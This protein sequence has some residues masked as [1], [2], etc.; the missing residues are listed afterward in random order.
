MRVRVSPGQKA[1]SGLKPKRFQLTCGFVSVS[2][3]QKAGSGLKQLLAT[4][5]IQR[6]DVSP[7]QK[8]GSGLKQWNP[9]RRKASLSGVSPGQKAGSGLKQRVDV[10]RIGDPASFSRPKSREWIETVR[11]HAEE[12]T[13]V[14]S[15]GQ[16]AGSGLKPITT[17]S[18]VVDEWFLPAKKP[19]VD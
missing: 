5:L 3:G 11:E 13:I 10:H 2:P 15:P 18:D 6:S 17:M 19:G 8:A 12:A 1:G 9:A 4:Q 7:G 16:K 14:V